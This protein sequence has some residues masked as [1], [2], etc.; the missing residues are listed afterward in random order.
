MAPQIYTSSLIAPPLV[1]HS[2]FTHLFSSTDANTVGGWPSSAP[3]FIDAATGTTLTRGQLKHLALS[4]G[5]GLKHRPATSTKRDDTVLIYSHNSLIYPVVVFGAVAAGL[6]CTFANNAYNARELAH[7]YTDS[8][9]K[10]IFASEEGVAT[11]R[12]TLKSLGV[13]KTE[14]DKRII[15]MTSGLEWAGGPSTPSKPELAGLLTAV[16]LLKLGTLKE[17]EKFEGQ[18]AN[19]TVYLCYSSGTT[20]K[21]KGVETTHRNITSVM[22][23]VSAAIKLDI[24]VDTMLGF[25]PFYHIYG[26]VKLLHWPLTCGAPVAVMTRFDPVQFCANVEKYKVTIALVVPP[27]LVVLS[28]HPAVEQHDLSTLRI[29]ISGAAPLGAA[30]SKQVIDRLQPQLK[31]NG[32]LK[33]LQGYGLTETSPTTHIVPPHAA[34][35]KMGSIGSLLP[36]LEVR[37]V[38]DGEGDGDIEA[39]EGQPGEV[40][41]RGPSIMKG[42][43]NNVTA[44]KD[45]ITADGWFKTGDIGIRDKD[46]FY[47]IVDRRKELIKY[48]GFQVPPAELESVLLTHP[49]IADSAVIGVESAKEA[50]ELPRAYVV[51]ARPDSVKTPA[52]KA[53]FSESIKKWIQSKVARHKYLRGGVVVVDVIPKSAAGKILRRE[54][55]ERAKEELAGRDPSDDNVKA[56]L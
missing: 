39:A 27:V 37:L 22:D 18:L 16:D 20:G 48:K 19:E 1:N 49:D 38:V 55:R 52:E 32:P 41:V 4:M 15:V 25:L 12:E 34:E 23:M 28:R 17:E 54:L 51:H 46:G 43:L 5:Y 8:R 42:Y 44:T 21:P 14:A 11:V 6:R 3:A 31:G 24:N 56:K 10:L 50:T 45:A 33:I 2:V 40:W 13:S 47:Y 30:L 29:L 53:T 9:A 7:Q 35:S 36:H 26:A